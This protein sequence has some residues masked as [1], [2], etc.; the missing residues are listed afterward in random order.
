MSSMNRKSNA[1]LSKSLFIR[2]LQ[3]HKS[4]YLHKYRPDLKDE[5]SE[6]QEAS[7]QIGRDVGVYAQK[8]FPNGVD[9]LFDDV[10]LTDQISRTTKE[11]EDGTPVIHEAAFSFD[12]IFVKVDILRKHEGEWEI[13]EVKNSTSVKDVHYNDVSIQYYVLKGAGIS[14]SKAF[15]V[16]INNQYV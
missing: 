11:I 2:G 9:I 10:T 6:Q 5:I 7:F 4:L 15:L 8:L 14:V 3:C 13:Y 16:H 1:Y 12:N